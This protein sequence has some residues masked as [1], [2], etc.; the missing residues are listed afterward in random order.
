MLPNWYNNYKEFIEKSIN[1][2]LENY[3]QNNITNKWLQRFKEVIFYS[4]KWWKRI[5]SILALEFYLIFSGKKNDE[6]RI[7]DDIMKFCISLE[8]I[9]AYSLVHDDL[10]SMDNDSFR[11]WK[12]TVWKKFSEYEAIL[13]WD[14][15]NSLA[16]EVLSE[17]KNS[18]TSVKLIKLL[19]KNIWFYWM[20]WWQ[21]DDMYFE[22][23]NLELNL[24]HLEKLHNKKTWALI[25]TSILWWIIISWNF[26]ELEKYSDFWKKTWLLFQIM[27]DVLDVEWNFEQTGKSVWWENKWFVYFMWLKKSKEYLNN[28]LT[29]SLYLIKDLN[30]DKLNFLVNLIWKRKK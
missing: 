15:L 21:V 18:K 23:N 10:P 27:D 9:H 20:V 30:S 28:L 24:E 26:I 17:I 13:A 2:Y 8:L 25:E 12:L 5:R 11:R 14:L 1:F 19:S 16:F 6:I 29:E 4:V 7:D 3:F 22:K